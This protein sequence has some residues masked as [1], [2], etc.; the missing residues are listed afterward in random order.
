MKDIALSIFRGPSPRPSPKGR[1]RRGGG[2]GAWVE[3]VALRR[4][5][6]RRAAGDESAGALD[7]SF[8]PL[9]RGRNGRSATIST[10]CAIAL[11][12]GQMTRGAEATAELKNVS[13]NGGIDEG[14]ARI[15][16]EG[17]F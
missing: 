10:L 11:L 13:I 7:N 2:I 1:G 8:R 4:V 14:K 9:L 6:P 3:L 16:I 15:T 17:S 5:A 12:C